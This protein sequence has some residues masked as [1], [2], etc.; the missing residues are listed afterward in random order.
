MVSSQDQPKNLFTNFVS[1]SENFIPKAHSTTISKNISNVL[2]TK[3]LPQFS[4]IAMIWSLFSQLK[5]AEPFHRHV[6][7]ERALHLP[8]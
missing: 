5:P 3:S 1:K 7:F 8:I 2:W 6:F 4:E